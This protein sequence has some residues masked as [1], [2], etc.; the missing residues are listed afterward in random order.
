MSNDIFYIVDELNKL[1]IRP[2]QIGEPKIESETVNEFYHTYL[3]ESCGCIYYAKILYRFINKYHEIN[4]IVA[5][6]AW[7]LNLEENNW[8]ELKSLNG[9]DF[10][11][12]PRGSTWCWGNNAK[13]GGIHENLD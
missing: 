6:R 11:L 1:T 5:I 7:E 10:L 9:R 12:N 8:M 3:L 2:L 4:N 13:V